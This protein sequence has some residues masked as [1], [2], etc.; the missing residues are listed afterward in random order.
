MNR[1]SLLLASGA[2]ALARPAFAQTATITGA[3]A[4]FPRPL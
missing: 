2:L 3:G 4:T 1:R